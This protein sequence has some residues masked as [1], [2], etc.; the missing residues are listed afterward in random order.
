[1]KKC[2]KPHDHLAIVIS[3][4]FRHYSLIV[5]HI[6]QIGFLSASLQ[7][8]DIA[9]PSKQLHVIF[10]LLSPM[11]HGHGHNGLVARNP[12]GPISGAKQDYAE[13][14]TGRSS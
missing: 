13:H 10:S 12:L 2:I 8:T 11:P 6:F 3:L 5:N 7:S 4:P 14:D 1:M 9:T